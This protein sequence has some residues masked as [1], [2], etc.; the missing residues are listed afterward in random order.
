MPTLFRLL[1]FLGVIIGGVYFGLSFIG[2]S[3]DPAPRQME[4]NL[5][6]IILKP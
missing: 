3:Y 2:T 6:P 5:R 4:K 1:F